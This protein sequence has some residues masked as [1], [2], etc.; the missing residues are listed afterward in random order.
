[1]HEIHQLPL[2]GDI[3]LDTTSVTFNFVYV[4]VIDGVK[5]LSMGVGS[6][7]FVLQHDISFFSSPD[8]YRCCP[9]LGSTRTPQYSTAQHG[10]AR[11]GTA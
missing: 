4:G 9:F 2:G 10:T 3:P 5:R 6:L 11:H 8:I 7:F 1:V